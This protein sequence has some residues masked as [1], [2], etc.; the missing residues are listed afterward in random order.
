MRE[1][2]LPSATILLLGA[3]GQIGLE[4]RKAFAAAGTRHRLIC[5]SRSSWQGT[6]FPQE[7]WLHVD[8][9][10]Q[11]SGPFDVVIN[12]IG[13]IHE[14]HETSFEQ[15]HVGVT[16]KILA[17]R[18]GWGRPRIVQISALGA[19]SNHES[20]FLRSKGQADALL[21][22]TPDTIVLR[23]SI[24]W[25][26]NTML[27]QKLRTL[28]TIARFGLGKMLV[29]AGFPATQIQPILGEDVGQAVVNAALGERREASYVVELV[30]PERIRFGELI[31]EMAAA[32]GRTVR[33]V[34]VSR[35][36]MESFVAHF[37]GV[38]F[39]GLINLEQFRLLFQ[40]NVGDVAQTERILGRKP[41]SGEWRVASG[42]TFSEAGG[43]DMWRVASGEMFSEA[44]GSDV[45]RVASGEM[46]SE[47]GGSDVWRV[48]SGETFSE[49]E[50]TG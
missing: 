14:T 6:R 1:S 38:W 7:E 40:D 17:Q 22:A 10:L 42:E 35:E 3:S 48:A 44:G 31:A 8:Q 18:E 13:A 9:Q 29:P 32:H 21:L 41:M 27:L 43:S 28:L 5:C 16:E 37:V 46:F 11:V 30:G 25:T 19:D 45:W 23:P 50:F 47:A 4:I 2:L 20:G 36:I 15:V 24:V 26:P 12:A 33:L 49:A 34:E 39:P